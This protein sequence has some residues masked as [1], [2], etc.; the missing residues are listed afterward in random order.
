LA[1]PLRVFPDPQGAALE[2][3]CVAQ[4]IVSLSALISTT[5][6]LLELVP[7]IMNGLQ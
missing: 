1:R 5:V 7:T 3:I 2:H 6:L 4:A